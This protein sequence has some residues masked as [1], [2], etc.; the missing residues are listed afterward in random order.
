MKVLLLAEWLHHVGGCETFIAAV[1]QGLVEAG[2]DASVFVVAPPVHARWRE[3]LGER[4]VAAEEGADTLDALRVHIRHLKPD[5]VHAIPLEQTAFRFAALTDRP[6]LIGTEPSDGSDR[7]H[8]TSVYGPAMA[9]A[10]PHFA[11]IHCFSSRAAENLRRWFGFDGQS[12]QLP[13]LCAFP[14]ETP[15]WQRREP[16]RRLVGW[17]RLS[18]EKGWTFLIESLAAIRRECGP[19]TLD[20]WGDG[21]LMPVLRDLVVSCGEREHVR[22]MGAY[23]NPF[24]LD[25]HN[26]DIALTPSFFEGL[27]YAF[28]EALWC[29]MPAIVTRVSGAPDLVAEGLLCRFV[30]PGDQRQLVDA[31]RGLYDSFASLA[32]HAAARRAVVAE[33]CTAASVVPGML[34][35]YR[36]TLAA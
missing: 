30:D 25:Q 1:C 14:V 36:R 19:L 34:D 32:N 31:V 6:P 3:A 11:G 2:I 20:L 16:A 27:P 15:L 29:G 4:C 7:C 22:L 26:Y 28:L 9:A 18:T 33:Q 21:P 8:W 24:C 12:K 5:L 13:P 17:G 23:P 10:L 35:L